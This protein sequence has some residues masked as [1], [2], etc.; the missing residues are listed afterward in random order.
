MEL[1]MNVCDTVT[2]LDYGSIIC[3]GTPAE[4]RADLNVQ[5]AYL[6][7]ELADVADG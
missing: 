1:V 6:G 3:T 2:V 4:V 5:A 7:A